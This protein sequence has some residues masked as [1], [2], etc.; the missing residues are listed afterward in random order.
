MLWP[1]TRTV[2]ATSTSRRL[3]SGNVLRLRCPGLFDAS[4]C[5]DFRVMCKG[6]G[7]LVSLR[8]TSCRQRLHG[9]NPAAASWATS[10]TVKSR[11]T[12]PTVKGK[13]ISPT[14]GGNLTLTLCWKTSSSMIGTKQPRT[15]GSKQRLQY[16]PSSAKKYMSWI[17]TSHEIL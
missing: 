17:Q 7:T 5:V 10:P 13:A 4:K 14:A 15:Y 11:A 3:H 6:L 16:A 8:P 12:S 9:W 1:T 2:I